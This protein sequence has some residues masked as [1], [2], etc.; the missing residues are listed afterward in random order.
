MK[1]CIFFSQERQAL[2]VIKEYCKLPA[3]SVVPQKTYSFHF[4]RISADNLKVKFLNP[5]VPK[6]PFLYPLKTS[7]NRKVF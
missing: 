3:T 7:E 1:T 6:A 4:L 5:F 2:E